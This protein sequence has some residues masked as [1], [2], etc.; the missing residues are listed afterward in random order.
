MDNWSI[1]LCDGSRKHFELAMEM[2]FEA[3]CPGNKVEFYATSEDNRHMV[4]IWGDSH[5]EGNILLGDRSDQNVKAQLKVLPYKMDLKAAIDF[6]WHWL[7]SAS[8]QGKEIWSDDVK[9]KVG[10]RLHTDYWGH[11]LGHHYGVIAITGEHQLIG[12]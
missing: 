8:N 4:L 9:R 7:Y 6:S 12:K 3:N 11:A 10:Y 1:N 2:A 5:K